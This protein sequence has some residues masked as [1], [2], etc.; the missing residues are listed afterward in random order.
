MSHQSP[1]PSNRHQPKPSVPP[2]QPKITRAGALWVSLIMG[3]LTLILLLIFIAQNTGSVPFT[4]LGWHWNMAL[5]VAILVAA[6]IG[7]LLTAM[8]GTVR[9]YQLRREAKKLTGRR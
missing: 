2:Q 8:V 4:F 5:G 6:V 1:A 3:F 7:G 9:I